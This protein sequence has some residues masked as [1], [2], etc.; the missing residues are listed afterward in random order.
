MDG[1]PG[2]RPHGTQDWQRLDAFVDAAFAFAVSLLIISGTEPLASFEDLSRALARTPAFAFG[3]GL[4]VLF[5][6]SHRTWSKLSPARNGWT[7]ALS[8]MLVFTILVFVFPLRLLTE[9]AT[10]F[11]SGGV[12]PGGGLMDDIADL[13][14]TYAIYG[15]GFALL[16]G[17]NVLLFRQAAQALAVGSLNRKAAVQWCVTWALSAGAGL[18]SAAIALTPLLAAAPWLPGVTYNLIPLGL[19]LILRRTKAKPAAA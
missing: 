19:F 15:A 6:L 7:T 13:R 5:W 8:L 18:L 10:H 12:L 1:S 17:L 2:L 3:F 4:I 9:T 16:S 14:W 11:I